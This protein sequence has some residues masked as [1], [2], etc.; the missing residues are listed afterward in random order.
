MLTKMVSI[1]QP[2]DPPASASQS[3]GTTSL[4]HC[5]RPRFFSIHLNIEFLYFKWESIW[6]WCLYSKTK[7]NKALY[8]FSNRLYSER[9]S[10]NF[11]PP[12][13]YLDFFDLGKI[14]ISV[15]YIR[16]HI[17]FVCILENR[18]EKGIVYFFWQ[19]IFRAI[20]LLKFRVPR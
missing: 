4:S 15:F 14:R 12:R 9:F 5:T 7:W 19:I 6:S 10:F 2:R 11:G 3:A 13:Y 1:C 20:L 18:V 8:I 17:E 16:E